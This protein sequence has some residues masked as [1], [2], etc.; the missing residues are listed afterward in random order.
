MDKDAK[1]HQQEPALGMHPRTTGDEITSRD[2]QTA[3]RLEFVGELAKHA[4]S[5]GVKAVV[6]WTGAFATNTN[7]DTR[8]DSAKAGLQFSVTTAGLMATLVSGTLL[9]ACPRCA[10]KPSVR[11]WHPVLGLCRGVAWHCAHGGR[12]R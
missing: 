12:G 11:S 7:T 5:E 4:V 1:E 8:T 6:K 9:A 2:I 3:V 10:H